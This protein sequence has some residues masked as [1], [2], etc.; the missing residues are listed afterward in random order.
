MS[1]IQM[2][3]NVIARFGENSYEAGYIQWVFSRRS[4]A[5]L[6]IAYRNL[7]KQLILMT[8]MKSQL[9]ERIYEKNAEK[10]KNY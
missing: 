5:Q 4:Y 1:A 9:L 6:V 8:D 7:M 2:K 10:R 3:Q